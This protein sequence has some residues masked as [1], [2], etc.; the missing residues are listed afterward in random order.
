MSREPLV[1]VVLAGLPGTGKS[2]LARALAEDLGAVLLD[3]D[4]VREALFGPHHVVYTDEQDDFVM[5]LVFEAVEHAAGTALATHV[6]LDGRTFTRRGQ[7]DDLRELVRRLG[8]TPLLIECVCDPDVA[9]ARLAEESRMHA[10]PAA[11]RSPE[12]Y[13]DLARHAVPIQL[14]KLVLDSGQETPEGMALRAIEYV[15]AAG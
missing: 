6:V 5:R 11:N 7:V 8:L 10:H 2:T 13:D 15:R 9:R 3:K 4:L 12:L 1:L 14:P